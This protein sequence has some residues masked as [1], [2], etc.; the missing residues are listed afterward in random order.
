VDDRILGV[1]LPASQARPSESRLSARAP[2]LPRNAMI[3]NDATRT[4]RI[5]R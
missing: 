3:S 4:P 2:L 1:S 5:R